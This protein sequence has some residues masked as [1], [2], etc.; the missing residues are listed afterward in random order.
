MEEFSACVCSE[1]NYM[2]SNEDH[3]GDRLGYI[4]CMPCPPNTFLN[5]GGTKTNWECIT[6][7]DPNMIIDITS[8]CICKDGYVKA[9]DSCILEE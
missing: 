1:D 4:Q 6:C 3:L 7:S 5:G 2:A 8:E 9:G